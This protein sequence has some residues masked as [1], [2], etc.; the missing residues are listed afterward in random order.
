MF[1]ISG[2]G[3]SAFAF[4]SD[5]MDETQSYTI[6]EDSY[7]AI[8]EYP[9]GAENAGAPSQFF[10]DFQA[11]SGRP[12]VTGNSVP[13]YEP[14]YGF[15]EPWYGLMEEE[16]FHEEFE[17]IYYEEEVYEP[18]EA[19]IYDNMYF[20]LEN[21]DQ[22]EGKRKPD[23]IVIK[24]KDASEVPGFEK[25]LQREIDK[26]Q[27]I[28][29]IG[30]LGVYVVQVEDLER[31]P[32]AVLN[33]FKNNRFIEYVEPN[34]ILDHQ[35]A[36]YEPDDPLYLK[37]QINASRMIKAPAGWGIM[38]EMKNPTKV[39]VAI[40][41]SGVAAHGDLVDLSKNEKGFPRG[42]SSV[43]SQAYSNDRKGHGTSVAGVVGAI[44]DNNIGIA[45]IN[46]NADIIP[47][48]VDDSLT[49][50]SVANVAKGVTWAADNKVKVINMSIGTT[51]DSITLK[52]AID[53]AYK[54]GCAIFAASGNA[55]KD[56]IDFP[57][58]Y[59]NVMGVGSTI[60]GTSRVST[61]NYGEGLDVVAIGSYYST[62]AAGG[63]APVSGTSFASPQVA[64]L[65]SLI[66]AIDPDATN[67]TVYALIK[68]NAKRLGGG[69]NKETGYGLIDIGATLTEALKNVWYEPDEQAYPTPPVITLNSFTEVTLF[70]GDKY[71]EMGYI[72]VDCFG[73]DISEYVTIGGLIDTS[74]A[75]IY[76]LTYTVTDE[77]GN[78]VETTRTIIVEEKPVEEPQEVEP[79]T[80]TI[81]GSN[82]IILHLDS[83]TPYME[84]GAQA[85]DTDGKD[86]SAY[87]EISGEVNRNKA[88]TYTITYRVNGKDGGEATAERDVWILAPS[89]EKIIRMPYG[90]SGQAK[91]GAK[92]THTGIVARNTGWLDF[93][94]SSIDKNMTINVQ[95]VNTTTREAV[96]S[97][98]FSA[99]GR[100]QYRAEE[101]K[102]ELTVTVDKSIGNSK[103][104]ISL[105]MPEVTEFD[106]EEAE[107]I[108]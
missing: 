83:G 77:G 10:S 27:K 8:A 44:G 82:P 91:Q 78:T 53:Y 89:L 92:V 47:V 76:T 102:Y 104:T 81:I 43:S 15:E 75:G 1:S 18:S 21:A 65:A 95:L 13:A 86:I 5:D 22:L 37:E 30:A 101:G 93:N 4:E 11:G 57:A 48:K 49:T 68:E 17:S 12:N 59:G 71:E 29:F 23:E 94:V 80:M 66:F 19:D 103:Y 34:Y 67:D 20:D 40:I 16:F 72:A 51:S 24:F 32:N 87:V 64:G 108:Y 99:T 42:F 74:K 96:I 25:Q 88:G 60:N 52:N 105:I 70:V 9:G 100:K 31:N 7:E 62:T 98:S 56:G 35:Y 58:R 63:Y 33:R 107:V 90:F 6:Y 69:L 85:V 38:R 61:S 50:V 97:D 79:P 28:G 45:G 54:Q 106:F 55:G 39:T 3:L 2:S 36:D 26:V 14:E 46:W 41:D 73:K 84:Q